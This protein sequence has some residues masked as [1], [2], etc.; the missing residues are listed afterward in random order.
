MGRIWEE[1]REGE[2]LSEYIA[3]KILFS[4][5]AVLLGISSW[6]GENNKPTMPPSDH[7]LLL[8]LTDSFYIHTGFPGLFLTRQCDFSWK[9]MSR[10]LLSQMGYWW[11]TGEQQGLAWQ[12]IELVG[13]LPGHKWELTCKVAGSLETN[14]A[15][16]ATHQ[17]C[18]R[19]LPIQ[20]T[21]S[22][23]Q[24]SL[25]IPAVH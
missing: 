2:L 24:G 8:S 3:W 7:T 20:P 13:M 12:A 19:K 1:M 5:K 10:R 9:D 22:L 17:S 4:I 15:W 11:Q 25:L 23:S 18:I 21:G 6:D 14:P 16:L